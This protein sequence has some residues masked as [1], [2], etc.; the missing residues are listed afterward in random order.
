MTHDEFNLIVERRIEHIR[1]TLVSKGA[2]YTMHGDRLYNFKRAAKMDLDETPAEALKGMWKKHLVSV[3]D[4]I[5]NPS[6]VS[7]HMIDE[8]IG[9]SIIYLFLLEGVF[10]E[11]L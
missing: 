7:R 10:M 8:K 3:F 6:I 1:K 4:M 11:D 2:E 5:E 9:D